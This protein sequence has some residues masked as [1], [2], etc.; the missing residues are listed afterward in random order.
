MLWLWSYLDAVA[1]LWTLW[2]YLDAV[3]ALWTLWSYLDA[4][5]VVLPGCCG[6]GPY[7]IDT[8]LAR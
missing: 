1:A 5:A 8:I 4:V 2:S 6:C 3:A 7:Y